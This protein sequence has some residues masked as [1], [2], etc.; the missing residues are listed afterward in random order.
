MKKAILTIALFSFAVFTFTACS[1]EVT[2]EAE[3]VES[4][5]EVEAETVEQESA[6]EPEEEVSV[7][8]NFEGLVGE[9]TVDAAT[10]GVRM[11]L[12]F[13]EDGT[14]S[15]KMGA[16]NASGTWEVI[17]DERIKLVTQNTTGQEWLVTDLTETTVNICWNPDKPSP[18]TI[19]MQRAK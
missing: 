13:G 6:P 7:L 11:D 14:F 18:K 5:T 8:G 9:W 19:P 3:E 2:N 16:V 15:Q 10:A 4:D 17:S 1:S 12:T